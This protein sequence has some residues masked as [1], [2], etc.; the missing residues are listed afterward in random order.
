MMLKSRFGITMALLTT[1]GTL[2]TLATPP[3][4]LAAKTTLCHENVSACPASQ[5]YSSGTTL[6]GETKSGTATWGGVTEAAKLATNLGNILCDSTVGLKT[7]ET[8][9][10]PL[11]GSITSLNFTNCTIT[12]GGETTGCTIGGGTGNANNLPY[13]SNM[14]ATGGGNG[15]LT[16][17]AGTGGNPGATLIC[18]FLITCTF[19][20]VPVALP[21][22]GGAPMAANALANEIA[23]ER[24]GGKCPSSSKWTA[25]YYLTSPNE[26]VFLT[27]VAAK[28]KL[29]KENVTACP[30]GQTYPAET[31]IEGETKSGG[32]TWGGLTDGS[33]LV[34][35]LGTLSC[36]SKIKGKTSEKEGEPLN[37]EISSLTFT[38]CG[39]SSE[40]GVSQE[41][42]IGGGTGNAGFLPYKSSLTATIGGS[43][44]LSIGS[45]TGGEPGFSVVCGE[46]MNCTF[47]KAP[48][49]LQVAG[50]AAMVAS[51]EAKAVVLNRA[52]SK[53]PTTASW[54]AKYLFTTPTENAFVTN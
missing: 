22:T 15:T 25:R 18:G 30:A 43:G 7:T 44:N 33:K 12:V 38:N 11:P 1:L 39:L 46:I 2:A 34:T 20:K 41:C 8:A 48:I 35:S 45:G 6:N 5:T 14:V 4:A 17:T 29:C 13:T 51:A 27:G 23:L 53:C 24:A 21:V 31:M 10:E 40:L 42:S 26:N 50:G 3:G 16:A 9:G 47:S 54:T 32:V 52:G 49:G 36:D 37:A 28:T 19:S